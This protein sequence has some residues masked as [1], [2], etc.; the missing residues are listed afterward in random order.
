MKAFQENL[1][2]M[3]GADTQG[4][5]VSMDSPFSNFAFS[6]QNGVTFPLLGDWGGS[7]T[8]QYGLLEKRDVQGV[9]MEVARRATFLIDKSGKI[10]E[11]QVD[12]EAVDPTKIVA[13]CERR[14]MKD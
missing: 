2:K 5:G 13:A 1:S 9:P 4:L 11:T 14:K 8:K 10:V 12:S 3:E 6:Q 7:V